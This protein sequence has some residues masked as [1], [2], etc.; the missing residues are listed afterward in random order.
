MKRSNA[1]SPEGEAFQNLKEKFGVVL[2]EEK[3]K[4]GVFIGPQIREVVHDS[5]FRQSLKELEFQPWNAVVSV[6]EIFF[7]NHRSD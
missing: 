6:I 5:N 7:R 4:A 1:L 2:T 3:L